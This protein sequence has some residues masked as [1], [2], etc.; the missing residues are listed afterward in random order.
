VGDVGNKSCAAGAALSFAGNALDLRAPTGVFTSVTG[1]VTARLET[2]DGY[3]F[4][5][6]VT[7]SGGIQKQLT[8]TVH[9]RVVK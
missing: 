6:N 2:L 7:L 3:T 4:D 9:V 8:S 1:N 5:G